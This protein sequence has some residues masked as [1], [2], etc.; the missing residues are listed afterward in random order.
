MSPTNQYGSNNQLN[1]AGNTRQTWYMTWDSG[2]LYV[3]ITNANL[4]E[5][6][7]IYLSSNPQTPP[8][9]GGN[10]NGST[11]GFNYDGTDFAQLPFRANFVTYFRDGYRE[12][13]HSDGNNGWGAQAANFGGYASGSGNVR[14]V[15]IPWAAITGGAM[16]AAFYFFGYLTS[17]GGYVYGQAPAD[18]AG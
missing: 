13:R 18:N 11:Q 2:N 16:P 8:L 10:A 6:A 5:G 9:G 1:N 17:S 4:S 15:A 14:E 12:Y 7:V 3:A